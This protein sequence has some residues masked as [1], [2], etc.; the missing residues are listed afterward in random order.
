MRAR[1]PGSVSFVKV[2]CH[3]TYADVASLRVS[4]AD[5]VG[6]DGADEMACL[7]ADS[8]AIGPA[9]ATAA[10]L[11][12]CAAQHVHRMMLEILAARREREEAAGAAMRQDDAEEP[13]HEMAELDGAPHALVLLQR[14]PRDAG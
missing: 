4:L 11:Q 2:K 6:N 12:S 10:R 14:V 5:K 8:H 3:I 7:G 1:R 13:A 9:I